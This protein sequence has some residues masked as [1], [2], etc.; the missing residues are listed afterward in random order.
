[1]NGKGFVITLE[2]N[3]RPV[4]PADREAL[5][6]LWEEAFEASQEDFLP[7]LAIADIQVLVYEKDGRLCGMATVVPV[8]V[9]TVGGV[10]LYGICIQKDF[11]GQGL[12]RSLMKDLESSS[13]MGGAEFCCL[14]PG[15]DGLSRTYESFGYTVPITLFSPTANGHPVSCQSKA[16]LDA[17]APSNPIGDAE[18]PCAGRL[19]RLD[20][21]TLPNDLYFTSPMGE[22]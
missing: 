22:I 14:I 11:R 17:V 3:L 20:S 19:K 13:A 6:L 4:T 21:V 8:T 16:F 7:L 12:F 10:Y 9:G 18:F 15:D 1:M 5:G 2:H